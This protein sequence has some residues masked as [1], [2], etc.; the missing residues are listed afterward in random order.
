MKYVILSFHP[1]VLFYAMSMIMVPLGVLFGLYIVAKKLMALQVSANY[2]LLD[3]LVLIAG[4]QFLL[5]AML[6]DM[7]ESDKDMREGGRTLREY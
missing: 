2:P 7:Q 4:L 3:A 1:L 6:F 5:F